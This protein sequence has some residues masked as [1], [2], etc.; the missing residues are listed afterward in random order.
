MLIQSNIQSLNPQ[1]NTPCYC[2]PNQVHGACWSI[3]RVITLKQP[4]TYGSMKLTIND[5]DVTS[6][7]KWSWSTDSVT[8]S[9]WSDWVV[10]D[11]IAMAQD[12]DFY[13][14]ILFKYK[15]IPTVWINN[16]SVC[17]DCLT[18]TIYDENPFLVDPCNILSGIGF[19]LYTGWDCAM[20]MQQHLADMVVCM[21]GIPILYFKV[22]PNVDTKSYTFKEYVMHSVTDVKQIKMMIP[23]G[24]M[25]SSRP[26]IGEWDMDFET[27]WETELSKTQFS[28][29]FGPTA[30]PKQRDFIW[31]PMQKRMYMVN[32]AYEEKNENLMWK[33][34]TWK[35]ALVKWQDQDNVSQ[36]EFEDAIDNLIVN[37]YEDVFARGEMREGELTGERELAPPEH[38]ATNLYPV[39]ASDWVRS[40]VTP[41]K[42]YIIDKNTNHGN[43]IVGKHK[44]LFQRGGRVRYQKKWCGDDGTLML[45]VDTNTKYVD[46]REGKILSIGE[47][48]MKYDSSID[49]LIWGE[50]KYELE[51]E[52]TYIILI[53]WGRG[54]GS[55]DLN[56]YKQG[57]P[58]DMPANKMSPTMFKFD[59][60]NP[61]VSDSLPLDE[62]L[63]WTGVPS[64]VDI[65]GNS[66]DVCGLKLYDEYI[67]D[68]NISEILKYNTSSPR[69]VI[70][71]QC[72]PLVGEH[73]YAV[74]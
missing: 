6:G 33:A 24:Q 44:Y 73:G 39:E 8:W 31:V 50:N 29:A 27:D 62:R 41:D 23:D 40:A 9:C 59:F 56:V 11:R 10:F 35:L 14:R 30:F 71:D 3:S 1:P 15:D 21:I 48:E 74:K 47:W 12:N 72:R 25:P 66:L 69:C 65:Y 51:P 70:N 64:E 13:V 22:D 20:M 36:D 67:S 43:I 4:I 7:C 54:T 45:I 5:D 55:L 68:A 60:E 52:S 46:G 61:I 53:R 38:A 26:S 34:V 17:S 32:T 49:G 42:L 2:H 18:I 19:D 28:T 63:V 37:K 58:K 57:C 16:V